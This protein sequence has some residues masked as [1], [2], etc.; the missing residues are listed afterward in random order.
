MLGLVISGGGL[1]SPFIPA[2]LELYFSRDGESLLL[3]NS[4]DAVCG[5][6]K[7]ETCHLIILPEYILRVKNESVIFPGIRF[8]QLMASPVR[9]AGYN[10]RPRSF[11]ERLRPARYIPDDAQWCPEQRYWYSRQNII[12]PPGVWVEGDVVS[13]KSIIIGEHSFISGNVKAGRDLVLQAHAA[14]NG[15]C[16]AGNIRLLYATGVSG[17]L[18]ACHQVLMMDLACA[19]EMSSP[20]SVVGDEVILHQGARVYGGIYAHKQAYVP[21]AGSD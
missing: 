14:V 4:C 18:V 9:V 15:N 1:V 7:S 16:I 10:Y 11:S 2:L 20:V 5:T 12:I 21:E 19:G 13:E 6:Y 17:C 8:K 3:H